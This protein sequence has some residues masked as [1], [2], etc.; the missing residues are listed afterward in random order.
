M[1]GRHSPPCSNIPQLETSKDL[2]DEYSR[3]VVTS[4]RR[5]LLIILNSRTATQLSICC[6]LLNLY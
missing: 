4:G 3:L 1:I 5:H 2:E 6:A